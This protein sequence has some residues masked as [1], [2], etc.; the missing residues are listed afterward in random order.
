MMKKLTICS[1]MY[2]NKSGHSDLLSLITC[3]LNIK[4]L[5]YPVESLISIWMNFQK[6]L[7]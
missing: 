4:C 7:K 3:V 5:K 6:I 1:I 2:K